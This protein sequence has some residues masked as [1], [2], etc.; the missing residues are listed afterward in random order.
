MKKIFLILT[1]LVFGCGY[2]DIDTVPNFKN[3]QL[4]E[5]ELIELCINKT[6]DNNNELCNN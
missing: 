5:Q 6:S 4:T 3:I 1:L 2:P